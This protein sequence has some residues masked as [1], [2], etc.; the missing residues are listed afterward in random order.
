MTQPT[1]TH[2]RRVRSFVLR[3]GRLT[4]GQQRALDSLWR[5]FGIEL[6]AR[7]DAIAMQKV[8][9]RDAPLHMEIGFGD[10]EALLELAAR[11]PRC[12]FLGVEVH[13]PG[14]GR[15]LQQIESRGVTNIRIFRADAV[16]V[17]QRAIPP[18][19]LTALYLFFP[20]PWPKK[21]HHKRRLLQPAF[22]EL[23]ASRLTHAGRLHFAT[24]WQ[25]YAEHARECLQQCAHFESTNSP[26]HPQRPQTKFERRGR[27]LGHA[28]WDIVARKV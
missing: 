12:N 9:A 21:R 25:P 20:D 11:N 10:G 27:A 3:E 19:A 4:R 8:F 14:I 16:E 7:V 23:A 1:H 24:D 17:L 13:R 6:P 5:K 15:L 18:A 22:L 2:P 26:P 28:V